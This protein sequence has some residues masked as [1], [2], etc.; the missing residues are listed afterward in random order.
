MGGLDFVIHEDEKENIY[1][2]LI[3]FAQHTKSLSV[4]QYLQG[5]WPGDLLRKSDFCSLKEL[6]LEGRFNLF[7]HFCLTN[8]CHIRLVEWAY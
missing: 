8:H 2:E 3:Q 1:S 6:D 4:K 7:L 5:T